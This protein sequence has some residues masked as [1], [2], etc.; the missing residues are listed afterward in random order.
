MLLIT[1]K[2]EQIRY[3]ELMRVYAETNREYGKQVYPKSSE[4][5]R[6][7]FAEQDLYDYLRFVLMSGGWFAAWKT[8]DGYQS[9]L[10]LEPYKDGLLITALETAPEVRLMGYADALLSGIRQNFA[11]SVIYAH[12]FNDNKISVHLHEKNGFVRIENCAEFIDGTVSYDACTY[13]LKN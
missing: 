3:A 13:R 9:A 10:R 1:Q 4:A 6:L 12:I 11:S 5:E 2:M 7:L 8:S